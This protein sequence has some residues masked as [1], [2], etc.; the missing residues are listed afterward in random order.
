MRIA[1]FDA[2]AVSWLAIVAA[3]CTSSDERAADPVVIEVE[4]QRTDALDLLVVLDATDSHSEERNALTSSLPAFLDRIVAGDPSAHRPAVTDLHVGVIDSDLGTADVAV[5]GCG[6]SG[7]VDGHDGV[8]FSGGTPL[9]SGCEEGA[10]RVRA[11]SRGQDLAALTS[12][13][14]CAIRSGFGCKWEQFLE[15]TLKALTPSTSDVA[16]LR[17]VG[18]ADGANAG[19]RR[20]GAVLAVLVLAYEDDCSVRDEDLYDATSSVYREEALALRCHRFPEA[21]WPIG[22]YAEGLARVVSGNLSRLVYGLLG[23]V[24][25]EV[26]YDAERPDPTALLAHPAMQNVVDPMDP[27]H[28]RPSCNAPGYGHAFPPRR[29][30]ELAG[31]WPR[32]RIAVATCPGWPAVDAYDVALA[33]MARRIGDALGQLCLPRTLPRGTDGEPTCA[34]TIDGV[35]LPRLGDDAAAS[36]WAVVAGADESCPERVVIT[37]DVRPDAGA[38]LR[39]E[40]AST[41]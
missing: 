5:P 1:T 10:P 13:M 18:H 28:L 23:G 39:F 14:A 29:L 17:G 40:C 6:D 33:A 21:Q 8:L 9:V 31:A 27:N 22:R 30:L 3:S 35:S 11:W 38:T 41:P 20:E 37:D 12:S 4:M 32:D 19:F 24:P 25:A 34:L 26:S 2:A 16:F 7:D 15:A 36:G